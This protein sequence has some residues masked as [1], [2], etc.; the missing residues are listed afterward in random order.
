[1]TWTTK[2][3][4]NAVNPP[5][6]FAGDLMTREQTSAFLG[7]SVITLDRWVK[8]GSIPDGVVFNNIKK[9]SKTALTGF[10]WNKVLEQQQE[11]LLKK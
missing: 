11:A 7:I 8:A 2:V 4:W 5:E 6:T 10:I 9:W 1:M 3:D